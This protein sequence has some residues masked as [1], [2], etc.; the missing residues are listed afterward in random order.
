MPLFDLTRRVE[1]GMPVYPGDPPVER[2]AWATHDADGYR[3]SRITLGTH[4]GIHVD[5]PAHTEPDPDAVP[6]PYT[7]DEFPPDAFRF[8]A[9]LADVT[10]R[11]DREAITPGDLP[12]LDDCDL[13]ALRTGWADHWGDD[14]YR[15]HPYL[16][17]DAAARLADA[18]VSIALDAL[19][20][21]PTPSPRAGDDEPSG[22][23]AHHALLDAGCLLVENLAPLDDLAAAARGAFTLHAS[24]LPVADGDGAPARVVAET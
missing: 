4:A 21:D 16:A 19:S 1:P 6:G 13:L 23:P 10:H 22:V 3:V 8:R 17:P 15:E 20:P 12:T 9:R 5:A 14:R 18:G 11:G 7:I 2:E 24:P